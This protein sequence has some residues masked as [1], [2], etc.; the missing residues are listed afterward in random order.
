[1]AD[2]ISDEIPGGIASELARN[3]VI[4]S[5]R[6]SGA[7]SPIGSQKGAVAG[8]EEPHDEADERDEEESHVL[9]SPNKYAAGGAMSPEAGTHQSR[10]LFGYGPGIVLRQPGDGQCCF[11]SM[12]ASSGT[13]I[14]LLTND[15]KK[16][17]GSTVAGLKNRMREYLLEGPNLDYKFDM[18]VGCPPESPDEDDIAK[19]A[20]IRQ[21]LLDDHDETPEEHAITMMEKCY[22]GG[23]A[24]MMVVA[25]ATDLVVQ[26]G[27]SAEVGGFTVFQP[28]VQFTPSTVDLA[29][30]PENMILKLVFNGT[31]HFDGFLTNLPGSSKSSPKPPIK[32]AL[33]N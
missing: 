8:N 32:M 24:E 11:F 23:V 2:D 33:S 3:P 14:K 19:M 21:V 28:I 4:P 7:S 1:M 27:R 15:Q 9:S 26:S 30:Y 29:C 22:Y 6:P 20:S 18:R 25:A 12:R 5:P 16:F 31:D 13:M 10:R 17:F